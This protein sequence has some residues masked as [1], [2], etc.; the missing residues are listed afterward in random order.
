MAAAKITY[1]DALIKQLLDD[2]GDDKEFD[3]A[4]QIA[5]H[6]EERFSVTAVDVVK[7]AN[8]GTFLIF[9]VSTDRWKEPREFSLLDNGSLAW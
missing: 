3:A 2:W 5:L 9:W 6:M 1:A 8:K 4:E 7:A